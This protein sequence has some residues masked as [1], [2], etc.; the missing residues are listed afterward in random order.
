[1]KEKDPLFRLGK[2]AFKIILYTLFLNFC[3]SCRDTKTIYPS[4]LFEYDNNIETRWSSPEN[5]N[6]IK[7]NGGRLNNGAK[8]HAYDSIGIGQSRVLLDIQAQGIINRIWV[9]INNRSPENTPLFE[10]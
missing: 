10:N 4:K 8:G 7:G 2:S 3:C 9:T 6:G 5:P 1:M